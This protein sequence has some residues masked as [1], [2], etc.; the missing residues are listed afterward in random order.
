MGAAGDIAVLDAAVGGGLP[1]HVYGTLQGRVP[2][3]AMITLNTGAFT[4]RAVAEAGDGS[5]IRAHLGRW[6]DT[7]KQRA[8]MVTVTFGQEPEVSSRRALGT[9]D[10][11]KAAYRAVIELFRERGVANVRWA[12]QFSDWSYRTAASAADHVSRWYP[13]DDYVD[14]VGV[15]ALN[16]SSCDADPTAENSLSKIGAAAIAFARAHGKEASIAEF[17]TAGG[18]RRVAW[19]QSAH[20]WIDA[21][22]DVIS[23]VYYYNRAPQANAACT[24]PLRTA[25][26]L[27]AFAALGRDG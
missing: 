26:E 18:E 6:A 11:Y 27:E 13:G 22:V 10:D 14:V 5:A 3:G 23:S 1:R 25:S 9:A 17:A 8:D 16:R 2:R 12:V 24:W 21:N 19:L 7:I 15:S 4:W 20:A